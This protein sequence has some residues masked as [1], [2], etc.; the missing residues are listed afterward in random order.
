M[1]KGHVSDIH[2]FCRQCTSVGV[3][4]R[5][6][7]YIP[8]LECIEPP[9]KVGLGCI[10]QTINQDLVASCIN[11]KEAVF[12]PVVYKTGGGRGHSTVT[13]QGTLS[14]TRVGN[15]ELECYRAGRVYVE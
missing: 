9:Q 11:V 8:F 2:Q 5:Q 13:N 3:V 1:I 6:T 7:T 4:I 15:L 12:L 14:N 10:H